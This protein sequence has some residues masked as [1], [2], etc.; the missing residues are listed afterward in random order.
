MLRNLGVN[1]CRHRCHALARPAGEGRAV[2]GIGPFGYEGAVIEL[3]LVYCLAADANKCV[4]QRDPF[5][6]WSSPVE[7]MMQA[8]IRAQSYLR[9]HPN[10]VLKK[11]R[12]EVDVPHQQSL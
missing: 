11:M 2:P 7:C 4:E 1:Q 10:R 8:Q 12:C 6:D 9:E 5:E 3:V